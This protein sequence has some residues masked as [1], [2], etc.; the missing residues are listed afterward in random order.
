MSERWV[1]NICPFLHFDNSR[2][3][4]YEHNISIASWNVKSV[5]DYLDIHPDHK[6]S[7]DQVSLLEG[8]KRLFPNYWDALHQRILEGRIEIVGGTYVMP[9]LIIPDG[10]SIA[11]QFLF[12]KNFIHGELGVNVRVGWAV[13]S[14]GHCAQLPQIL[15]LCGLDS[16]YFWR[17]MPY[18]GPTEFVWKGPDGS[19]V[20]AIFLSNGF[21]SAAWLSENTREAF[22]RLLRIV[23]ETGEKASSNNIFLPVGGELVPPLPH[24]SEIVTQ[25]NT[26]FSDMRIAIV[27]PGEFADKLK[28]VQVNL[29]MISGSLDSGRFTGIRSGGLAA[30]PKLKIMN[31]RLESLLYLCELYLSLARITTKSADLDN[32]WKILLFNQD[33]NI[34]RGTLADEPYKLAKRR[35]EQAIDQVQQILED[36][37]NEVSSG[38]E[39][40]TENNSFAV[41]NP[42]PWTR[43]DLVRTIIDTS[44]I[45]NDFFEIRDSEG[46]PV[47][48]QIVSEV[49]EKSIE[50]VLI[51]VDLPSLGHR[52]YSVVGVDK[53]PEFESSLRTGKTWIESSHF[54]IELDEFNGSLSRVYDK[55]NQ[56]ELLREPA[57]H[58]MFE[59]DVGDLYRYSIPEF[60]GESPGTS[61]LRFPAGINLVESG[62][63]RSVLEISCEFEGST[64]KDRI[65]VYDN[66]HRIDFELDLD[67]KARDKRVRLYF[68][69]T[70]FTDRIQ[71][72]SQFGS[73]IKI[74]VPG[75]PD[76]WNDRTGGIFSALDWIDCCGPEIGL[77]LSA[78]GLHEFEFRDGILKTT[79][80]RSVDY[81]SRG[82]DDDVTETRTARESGMHEFRYTLYPHKGD[83]IEGR[84]WQVSTEHRL[85]LIAYP[86]DGV[87]GPS[88]LEVSN[89]KIEGVDLMLS[90]YKPRRENE[91]IIRLYEPKGTNGT[92]KLTFHREI[93]RIEMLDIL[94]RDIGELG[95]SEHSFDIPID[96][97]SIVTLC[98]KFKP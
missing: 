77:C 82:L 86:L 56:S 47:T 75:Q 11:R 5:L 38:I 87:S 68:P 95:H 28:G 93:E 9:D 23:E 16:Y 62:P 2:T 81:L 36:A 92:A 90:C 41:H 58:L 85:P 97:Y 30:R 55:K 44:R 29:P 33:H 22:F 66:M 52:V 27:T 64:K 98:V 79:L 37:V 61:T 53:K 69:L 49:D 84:S 31:R 8:F 88:E 3:Q 15:R 76:N 39:H 78:P 20:N 57:N 67:F 17:G 70:I 73:E 4:T 10:E 40:D 1:V 45:Q 83:W 26:T 50:V 7:F 74:N 59:N 96:A 46:I 72:G 63:V 60:T 6:F 14:A 91:F 43:S 24:L 35:Y 54:I 13:D 48:Y 89:L 80:L 51:S 42:T 25:W 65:I 12:G 19:R 71:V 94:E 32:I 34:I 21:D 18:D